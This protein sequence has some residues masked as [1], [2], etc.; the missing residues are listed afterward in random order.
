MK[1]Y[2]PSGGGIYLDYRADGA[3]LVPVGSGERRAPVSVAAADYGG[4]AVLRLEPRYVIIPGTE[5]ASITRWELRSVPTVGKR[6]RG[7][8]R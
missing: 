2:N 6:R 7:R 8:S 5:D 3:G 1:W 4:L